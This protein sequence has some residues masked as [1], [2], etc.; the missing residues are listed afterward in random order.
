MDFIISSERKIV[1][2]QA[3]TIQT[4]DL[5]KIQSMDEIYHAIQDKHPNFKILKCF[6]SLS[7]IEESVLNIMT[8]QTKS[9]LL[10]TADDALKEIIGQEMFDRVKSVKEEFRNP[11]QM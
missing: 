3:T 6:V 11:K 5:D 4:V 8:D 1:L 9:D 10:I 7:P 2:I